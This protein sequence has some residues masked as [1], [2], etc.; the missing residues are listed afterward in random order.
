MSDV[1]GV[2]PLENS[3]RGV[4]CAA[5]VVACQLAVDGAALYNVNISMHNVWRGRRETRDGSAVTLGLNTITFGA[6]PTFMDL[7]FANSTY[8]SGYAGRSIEF[9]CAGKYLR[10]GDLARKVTVNINAS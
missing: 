2:R 6:K 9:F 7:P 1:C 8:P 3:L 10:S 4:L 5:V